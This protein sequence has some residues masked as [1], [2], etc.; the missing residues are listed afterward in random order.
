MSRLKQA[1][2]RRRF[3]AAASAGACAISLSSCRQ[4]PE[5]GHPADG[6]EDPARGFIDAHVHVWTPDTAAYGL[7]PG[8]SKAQMKPASFTPGELFERMQ[9]AGVT[10]VVLIQMSYYGFD[11]SYMLDTIRDHPG[12]FSGVAVINENGADPVEKMRRL[13]EKGVRGFRLRPDRK[14]SP[15]W[16]NSPAMKKMWEFAA[17]QKLAMCP[18]IDAEDLS[19]VDRM[20]SR[21]PQTPVVIDH[22]A[23]IGHDGTF[24][25]KELDNLCALARFEHTYVKLSAFY[26]L[27]RK[28]PPYDDLAPLI[29]RVLAAFGPGRLMWAT[30][31]P[32]QVNPPH[33]Y[34][35]SIDLIRSRLAFLK[36][37]EREWLLRG[38]AEKVFFS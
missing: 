38:T 35:A 16:L 11:N 8:Y 26:Y 36:E 25:E 14:G 4:A 29:R 15:D 24:D 13:K 18:L 6:T 28:H 33:T 22:F 12:V 19:A 17:G 37:S 23:R 21:H 10:R 7:A 34:T 3:L 30:D 31:A 32:F 5:T 2:S 20:C 9:P 27:G 1:L